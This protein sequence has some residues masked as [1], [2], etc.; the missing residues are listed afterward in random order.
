MD[1]TLPQGDNPTQYLNSF[2][3]PEEYRTGI[4]I[5]GVFFQCQAYDIA[6]NQMEIQIGNGPDYKVFQGIEN[7]TFRL[8]CSTSTADLVC[9][10]YTGLTWNA[11]VTNVYAATPYIL[12][13]YGLYGMMLDL[14]R[15]III[16][17]EAA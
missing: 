5:L 16:G 15:M 12:R 14:Q 10:E 6:G 9:E 11:G 8:G 17:T 3:I 1:V 4:D 2:E 13:R 7:G